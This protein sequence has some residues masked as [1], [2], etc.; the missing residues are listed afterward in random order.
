[1]R[2]REEE[3]HIQ[4]MDIFNEFYKQNNGVSSFTLDEDELNGMLSIDVK[5]EE[6]GK[7]YHEKSETDIF[8]KFITR[9]NK[10]ILIFIKLGTGEDNLWEH[11]LF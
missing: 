6:N 10:L 3:L 1:M 4:V 8:Y 7:F 5:D 9:K 11:Q 2:T